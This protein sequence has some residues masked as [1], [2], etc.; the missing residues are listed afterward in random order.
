MNIPTGFGGKEPICIKAAL[1]IGLIAILFACSPISAQSLILDTNF[2]PHLTRITTR[3]QIVK[4]QSD[5]KILVAGDFVE[6]AG[7]IRHRLARLN[8]D[9]TVDLTFNPGTI[10]Q[11]GLIVDLARQS[12]GKVVIAGY[13]THVDGV[14]RSYL[15]RLN[16]DASVDTSF[17]T[18]TGPNNQVTGLLLQSDGKIVISGNFTSVNGISRSTLARLDTDGTLDTSF[19]PGTGIAGS[20][21]YISQMVQQGDGKI[22]IGGKFTSINGQTRSGIARLNTNGSVDDTF[23]PSGVTLS[24]ATVSDLVLQANGM[25]VI[26]GGFNRVNGS[27]RT[28]L[29]RLTTSGILDSSFSAP[30]SDTRVFSIALQSDGKVLVGGEF[31]TLGG[32][33]R[34]S[35]ARLTTSGALD[36][37]FDPGDAARHTTFSIAVQTDGKILLGNFANVTNQFALERLLSSGPQDATFNVS[38]L[39]SPIIYASALQPDGKLLVAGDFEYVN[40]MPRRRLARIN[41]NGTLDTSFDP[42]TGPSGSL[43]YIYAMALQSDGKVVVGGGFTSINGIT[44]NRIARV[45]SDGTLDT[46]FD[47]GTGSNGRVFALALQ[48]DGKIIAGGNFTTY[49]ST[50]KPNLVRLSSVGT[51]DTTFTNGAGPNGQVSTIAL[52]PDGKVLIGGTFS[53]YNGTNRGG[54][55]RLHS[56]GLIDTSFVPIGVSLTEAKVCAVQPDGTILFGGYFYYTSGDT[57]WT[58]LQR[59]RSDGTLLQKLATGPEFSEMVHSLGSLADGST[60]FGGGFWTVNKPSPVRFARLQSDGQID[61]EFTSTQPMFDQVLTISTGI[62]GW[63]VCAGDFSKFYGVNRSGVARLIDMRPRLEIIENPPVGEVQLSVLGQTGEDYRV[64]VSSTLTNWTSVTNFTATASDTVIRDS[65]AM[66]RRF[67]RAVWEP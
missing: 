45:N 51:L 14:A 8:S 66:P 18:G 23:A 33:T 26:C 62:N 10:V 43:Q 38:M 58:T 41:P 63:V 21:S 16:A 7:S 56:T 6:I 46:G 11:G 55:A 31:N 22:V 27:S 1:W 36:A 65:S 2:N 64:E 28:N 24:S 44:R 3:V 30:V 35:I 29:A 25:I 15:A 19:D 17:N 52:Q 59:L 32:I 34:T 37:T 4:L 47:P 57:N 50:S 49:N 40:S 67:Y 61:T 13:F 9:G 39:N 20:S 5:G 53:Q 12:D 48:N 60:I 42:G 54:R